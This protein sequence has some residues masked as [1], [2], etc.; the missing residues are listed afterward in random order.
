MSTHKIYQNLSKY[1]QNIHSFGQD[2]NWKCNNL[3]NFIKFLFGEN[4]SLLFSFFDDLI[5][6]LN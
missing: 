6:K 5:L 1:P 2:W 3:G 4:F